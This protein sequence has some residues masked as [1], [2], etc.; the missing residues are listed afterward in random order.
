[1]AESQEGVILDTAERRAG[2]RTVRTL[3]GSLGDLGFLVKRLLRTGGK[4]RGGSSTTIAISPTI[5][6]PWP[7]RRPRFSGCFESSA[8][9][10]ASFWRTRGN[11]PRLPC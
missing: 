7:L 3:I 1:M 11:R 10:D 4:A 2:G 9:R 6:G 5:C 8:A